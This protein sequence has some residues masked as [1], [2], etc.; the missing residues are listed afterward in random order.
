MPDIFI[1]TSEV[2]FSEKL[3]CGR[4]PVKVPSFMDVHNW[5]GEWETERFRS[6]ETL[7]EP[8]MLFYDVGSFDGWQSAIISRFVG[9]GKNMVLIEPVAEN[10]ANI[11]ATWEANGIGKPGIA[12]KGFVGVEQGRSGA[13]VSVNGDWPQGVDYSKL[14]A[15]TKFQHINENAETPGV[16]L[17]VL[18]FVA[19]SPKA[20]N[21][22]VEGAELIVLKS[23]EMVLRICSPIVWI[24]IHPE[25]MRDRYQHEPDE[26]HDFMRRLGYEM[27]LLGIDHEEHWIARR[28]P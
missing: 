18:A 26:V 23:A 14:I 1:P 9:G 13:V 8:G 3:V 15:V 27:Y 21:I 4:Y 22:D 7:L 24:S 2:T 11:K 17:D 19:G 10:W 20:I 6:M 25:F 28:R 12:F 5:W 16:P